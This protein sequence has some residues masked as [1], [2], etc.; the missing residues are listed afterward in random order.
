MDSK[1]GA[2]VAPLIERGSRVIV[3]SEAGHH[4][5]SDNPTAFNQA[6]IA[7]VLSMDMVDHE[8][9]EYIFS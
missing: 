1:A 6:F 3:I 5:Y 7:E 9:V 8:H 2:K 4:L